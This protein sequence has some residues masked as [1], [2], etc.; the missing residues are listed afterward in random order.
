MSENRIRVGCKKE[1]NNVPPNP[2]N[3][4]TEKT[5]N[6]SMSAP[7]NPRKKNLIQSSGTARRP[8]IRPPRRSTPNHSR[9]EKKERAEQRLKLKMMSRFI[10]VWLTKKSES[11]VKTKKIPPK[12]SPIAMVSK[13]KFRGN[14]DKIPPCR[15][16]NPR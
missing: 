14:M 2:V 7:L 8:L 15:H 5:S 1:E 3:D 13:D 11:N 12:P 10:I 6:R 16:N 4:V 9:E